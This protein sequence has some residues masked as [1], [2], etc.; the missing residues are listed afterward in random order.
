M[1]VITLLTTLVSWIRRLSRRLHEPLE[2]VFSTATLQWVRRVS[3]L[4]KFIRARC[5]AKSALLIMTNLKVSRSYFMLNRTS[6]AIPCSRNGLTV[7]LSN[8]QMVQ[9]SLYKPSRSKSIRFRRL[10]RGSGSQSNTACFV[11]ALHSTSQLTR[12]C[13]A[14]Y[15]GIT[16]IPT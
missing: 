10:K 16:R 4:T 12:K 5:T 11:T 3:V 7:T 15:P 6:K 1:E 13:K 14:N 9:A 2:S 8:C